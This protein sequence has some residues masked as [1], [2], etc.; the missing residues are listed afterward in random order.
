MTLRVVR[1]GE[2]AFIRD[3][4]KGTGTLDSGKQ[5]RAE[6]WF[7][8][9]GTWHLSLRITGHAGAGPYLE[10]AVARPQSRGQSALPWRPEEEQP[11]RCLCEALCMVR[12]DQPGPNQTRTAIRQTAGFQSTEGN[13]R[14]LPVLYVDPVLLPI[15]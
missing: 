1:R 7:R 5:G 10:L 14:P 9:E 12:H 13:R 6:K 2:Q 11:S 8:S 3:R 15:R 4:V